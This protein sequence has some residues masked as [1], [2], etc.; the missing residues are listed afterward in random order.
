MPLGNSVYLSLGAAPESTSLYNSLVSSYQWFDKA[1][2]YATGAASLVGQ[3]SFSRSYGKMTRRNQRRAP[4]LSHSAT[5]KQVDNAIA[6]IG[7][8]FSDMNFQVIRPNGSTLKAIVHVT[9]GR[10]LRATLVLKGLVIEWVVVKGCNE[11][12]GDAESEIWNESD[13]LVFRKLTEN[14]NAAMLN[15]NY[16]M[17]P[18]FSL[19]SFITYLHS[20]D[21]L[22]TD[23]CKKCGYHL[24]NH[25]PPTW[26]EFKTLEPFHE[27]C[28]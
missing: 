6:Q 7:R 20:F 8:P 14:A 11:E 22:F 25:L 13:Y 28:R 27:D 15:Y 9:L 21:T 17:Y 23:K 4:N 26:R 19:K 16:P 3:N 12:L 5:P 24:R 1:K 2:E 18:E 10:V